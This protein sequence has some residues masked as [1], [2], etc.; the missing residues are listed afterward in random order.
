[1]R[2]RILI[3]YWTVI[4]IRINVQTIDPGEWGTTSNLQQFPNCQ[5]LMGKL[6]GTSVQSLSKS[7]LKVLGNSSMVLLHCKLD[8]R[9][10]FVRPE[11]EQ[12]F[13]SYLVTHWAGLSPTGKTQDF[14]TAQNWTNF[15]K[16]FVAEWDSSV[17]G[18]GHDNWVRQWHAIAPQQFKMYCKFVIRVESLGKCL[19]KRD[20]EILD[21]IKV[22]A[23]DD[24]ALW[25]QNCD[26]LA[27]VRKALLDREG[28][29]KNVGASSESTDAKFMRADDSAFRRLEEQLAHLE[30]GGGRGRGRGAANIQSY[31]CKQFGHMMKDCPLQQNHLQLAQMFGQP[32]PQPQFTPMGKPTLSTQGLMQVAQTYF[33]GNRTFQKSF[34]PNQNPNL[35]A[36][37]KGQGNGQRM[38][39]RGWGKPQQPRNNGYAGISDAQ[40]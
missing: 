17:L 31:L 7:K 12:W 33:P 26:T 13:S 11:E 27:G 20:A 8:S 1:M 21:L 38:F 15:W 5:S 29:A 3:Q 37:P 18:G 25:I 10:I 30:Q 36:R 14:R 16:S 24:I 23:P 4:R 35:P 32:R 34:R 19:D 39:N 2:M 22:C 40:A 28:W 9:M 6:K